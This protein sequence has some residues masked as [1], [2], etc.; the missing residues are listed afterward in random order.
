[1]KWMVPVL[2]DRNGRPRK[3]QKSEATPVASEIPAYVRDKT[4]RDAFES[5][6]RLR[7]YTVRKT[8][9]GSYNPA[10]LNEMWAAWRDSTAR[11]PDYAAMEREHFGDPQKGTGIYAPRNE[12]SSPMDEPK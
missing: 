2:V 10:L 5:W 4:E 8:R 1:M 3:V 9:E 7:G 6:A 12:R 11:E